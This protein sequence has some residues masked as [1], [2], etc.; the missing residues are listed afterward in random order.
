MYGPSDMVAG[1]ARSSTSQ[2]LLQSVPVN[3]RANQTT[4]VTVDLSGELGVIQGGVTLNGAVPGPGLSLCVAPRASGGG[5][6]ESPG[7]DGFTWCMD[8]PATGQF[9]LLLP[10]GRG[11]GWICSP[12]LVMAGCVR[13]PSASG[14]GPRL[15][16]WEFTFEVQAGKTVLVSP[17]IRP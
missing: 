6:G 11:R 10:S 14:S 15:L 2:V 3:V 7:P 5:G 16:K 12:E 8:L 9:R 13:D 4:V 17:A 1:S